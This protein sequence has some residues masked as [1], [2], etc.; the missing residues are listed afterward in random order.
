MA[1]GL[2]LVVGVSSV[3]PSK[4]ASPFPALPG[5]TPDALSMAE[6]ARKQKFWT[7][8][9]LN[10]DAN[11]GDVLDAI[12]WAAA[13]LQAGDIFMLYF[14]GHGTTVPSASGPKNEAAWLLYDRVVTK[15]EVQSL[16]TSF[17]AG[18]RIVVIVD[19]CNS[20][21]ILVPTA[22]AK[23]VEE[24]GNLS[25][26]I[27]SVPAFKTQETVN[28]VSPVKPEPTDL[29]ATIFLLASSGPDENS[30]SLTT[31][32]LFT[33]KLL[34]VWN[35]GRFTGTYVDFHLAITELVK[36]HQLPFFQPFG[37]PNTAFATQ[38]PFT[39]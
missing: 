16:V 30:I 25:F 26:L 3:D 17:R 31:H 4:Y 22:E 20:G 7:R 5:A 35:D 11:S 28:T 10:A 9:L 8:L 37:V 18:V 1:T 23:L 2:S 33:Q 12:Q 29:A 19:S 27:K 36:A 34:P 13:A 24:F 39:I 6:I 15:S 14:S 38:K 32:G 21:G